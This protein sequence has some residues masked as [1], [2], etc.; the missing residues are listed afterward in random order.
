M[1][2]SAV[3]KIDDRVPNCLKVFVAEQRARQLRSV[4]AAT[5]TIYFVEQL[6]DL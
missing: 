3:A 2:I 4:L 1:T 6:F 5:E